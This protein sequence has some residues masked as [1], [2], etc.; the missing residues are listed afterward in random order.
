MPWSL[1]VL[2]AH[3]SIADEPIARHFRISHA[4]TKRNTRRMATQ[5]EEP[6]CSSRICRSSIRARSTS[7]SRRHDPVGVKIPT[8]P[9]DDIIHARRG[10]LGYDPARVAAPVALIRAEWD[11]V[12]ADAPCAP[13]REYWLPDGGRSAAGAAARR[14]GLKDNR[15]AT[16]VR[17][18][19]RGAAEDG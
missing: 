13:P 14:P 12:I 11:G 4:L 1:Q 10:D 19:L 15:R 16:H 8:G 9:F 3:T 17:G 5:C 6:A 2:L 7:G 18:D